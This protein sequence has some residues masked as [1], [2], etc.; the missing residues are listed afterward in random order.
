MFR[1]IPPEANP[2]PDPEP[3]FGKF[4]ADFSYIGIVCDAGIL[5]AEFSPR[6][7]Q[8]ADDDFMSTRLMTI[9]ELEDIFYQPENIP[10][11]SYAKFHYLCEIHAGMYDLRKSQDDLRNQLVFLDEFHRPYPRVS[12]KKLLDDTPQVTRILNSIFSR[13]GQFCGQR[14]PTNQT[15]ANETNELEA[16]NFVEFATRDEEM[17]RPENHKHPPTP[18]E[19]PR[20]RPG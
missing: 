19:G 10:L 13:A 6:R 14:P 8:E 5:K 2:N 3:P 16:A 1:W 9:E 4:Q 12:I 18:R 7:F 20:L 11:R 17:E 15:S